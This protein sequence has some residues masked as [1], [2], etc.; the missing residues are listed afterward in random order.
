M[1][2]ICFYFS[3][4]YCLVS[5]QRPQSRSQRRPLSAMTL[6]S[7]NED[8]SYAENQAVHSVSDD[9]RVSDPH[10]PSSNNAR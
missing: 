3:H 8:M 9:E 1:I 4:H 10:R 6:T 2:K 5:E 7:A